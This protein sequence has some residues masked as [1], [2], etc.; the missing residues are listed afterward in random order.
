LSYVFLGL[1]NFSFNSSND[2]IY[3]TVNWKR[4]DSK[5][6]WSIMNTISAIF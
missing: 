3:C 6:G 4:C 2:K 5:R 1:F